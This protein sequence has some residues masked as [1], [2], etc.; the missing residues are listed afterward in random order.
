MNGKE[1]GN[2]YSGGYID[3]I[4]FRVWGSH[5]SDLVL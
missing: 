2:D 1:A 3:Y 5:V 4:G